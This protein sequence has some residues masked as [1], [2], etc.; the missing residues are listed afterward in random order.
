MYEQEPNR[1]LAENFINTG[2]EKSKALFKIR[3]KSLK[4]YETHWH[5]YFEI[6]MLVEGRANHILNGRKYD[7]K[8]GDIYL[9]TPIDFHEIHPTSPKTTVMNIMFTEELVSD[10]LLFY[11][12]NT[13]ENII[14]HLDEKEY[15]FLYTII[16]RAISEYTEKQIFSQNMVRNIIECIFI[17][18][19]RK[20]NIL[21]RQENRE[22]GSMQKV[23][24]YVHHHFREDPSLEE[25][26][27]V[28]GLNPG[29]F[30]SVFH[31]FTGKTY[32]KYLNELKM[33]YAKKLLLSGNLSVTEVC[34]NCGYNTLSHFLREFKKYHGITPAD[35][36]RNI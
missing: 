26:A 22:Y 15:N 32:K 12:F 24:M 27:L 5:D 34:Y 7:L 18:L 36:R 4:D 19:G 13:H 11:F 10:E 28:A 1:L 17:T 20:F 16:D 6:E 30:S 25:I 14:G 8:K 33:N 21:S 35:M 9:L 29:Y 3:K 31:Q 2:E 23:L